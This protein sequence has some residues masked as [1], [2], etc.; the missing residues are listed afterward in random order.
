[1]DLFDYT[2]DEDEIFTLGGQALFA[3]IAG[4]LLALAIYL[5]LFHL[6]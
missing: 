1:M 4:L 2:V 3:G 5:V 6:V